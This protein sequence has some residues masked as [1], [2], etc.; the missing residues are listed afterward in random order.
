MP[1]F[2]KCF[3]AFVGPLKCFHLGRP[4]PGNRSSGDTCCYFRHRPIRHFDRSDVVHSI[5]PTFALAHDFV[6]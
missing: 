5:G 2:L 6:G 4:F 3:L 1:S